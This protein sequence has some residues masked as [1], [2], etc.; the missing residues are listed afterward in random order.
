MLASLRTLSLISM[1]SLLT[2]CATQPQQQGVGDLPSV[3]KQGNV[4]QLLQ[5][6]DQSKPEQALLLRLSAIDL[7]L[8]QGNLPYV[9][10]MLDE[11]SLEK[12]QP[13][14]QKIRSFTF[15]C[16]NA[17]NAVALGRG[18]VRPA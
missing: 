14:Q 5:Q 11:Q 13:A 6:A 17:E 9:Q 15:L 2:A 1:A 16:S 3:V 18:F 4:A 8:R 10:R 12:M 7:A